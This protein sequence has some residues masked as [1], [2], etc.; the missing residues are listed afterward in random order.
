MALY[1]LIGGSRGI[2]GAAAEHLVKQGHEVLAVSRTPAQAGAW[3]EAD[4][5]TD[6]GI[7]AVRAAVEARLKEGAALDGL[8]YLGGVW[9]DGAFTDAYDF[10]ASPMEETR[11]V[12]SVNLTAPILLAQALAPY[13]ARSKNPRIILNGSTSGL[14]NSGSP[15]VAN[16]AAKFGLQGA[17]EALNQVLRGHGIG[18]TV[19]NFGNVA[20]PEVLDDIETGL[21]GTQVPIPIADLLAT[22]D[23]LLQISADS[24]PQSIDLRQKVPESAGA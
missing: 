15:E 5:A 11:F 3:I 19:V 2:G 10:F 17:M 18:V 4:I 22:Y 9:E 12:I 24:V 6:A 7:L 16:T 14:P 8:L 20:T 1:V 13:L 23:Y 21:F